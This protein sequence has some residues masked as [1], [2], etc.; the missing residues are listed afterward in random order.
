MSEDVGGLSND[1]GEIILS[2]FFVD[3]VDSQRLGKVDWYAKESTSIEERT[4]R[5]VKNS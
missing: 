1:D 3:Q 5:V 2:S 4:S